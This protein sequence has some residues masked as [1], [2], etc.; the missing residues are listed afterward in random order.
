MMGKSSVRRKQQSQTFGSLG[1]FLEWETP[2]FSCS[3][4]VHIGLRGGGGPQNTAETASKG[5][6][7]G[8]RGGKKLL[9]SISNKS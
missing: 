7:A 8:G 3:G 6:N 9:N 2:S 4:H 1:C 5:K